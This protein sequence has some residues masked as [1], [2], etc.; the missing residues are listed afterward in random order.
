MKKKSLNLIFILIIFIGYSQKKDIEI[1]S[2]QQED[3]FTLKAINNSNV[4]Q[5]ITL[6]IVS[7]NLKGY[8]NP[9]TRLI[10]S[11]SDVELI[12][13]FFINNKRAEYSLSYNYKPILTIEEKII[14][15]KKLWAK[16]IINEKA[17][18]LVVE[19]WLSDKPNT[20]GKFILIDFWATWCGP[21]RKVIPELNSFQKEFKDKLI[22]IGISD[23]PTI[24]VTN[25]KNP[26]IEYFNAIDTKRRFYNLLEV[27]GI[28]HCIL[29]DPN[30]IVRWEGFPLL[31]GYEL[32]SEIIKN[33]IE[34]EI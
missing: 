6:T 9:I 31:E 15:E 14:Q 21:C 5:E 18:E 7:T 30:G 27:K 32:T 22:V 16:S 19:K 25:Q 4:Q 1:I 3:G 34:K 8:L 20:D 17:P 13:L 23:E 29:I 26:K 10:P 12:K 24:K 2:I 33:I 28:P 11:K